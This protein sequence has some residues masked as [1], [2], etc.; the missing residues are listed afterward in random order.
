LK[1]N[2]E[3]IA[4]ERKKNGGPG[5]YLMKDKTQVYQHLWTHISNDGHP[6]YSPFNDGTLV[7]TPIQ[8]RDV[9]RK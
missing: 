1:N 7:L 5:Y 4:F 9:Y 3:I 2:E 8:I 6:S